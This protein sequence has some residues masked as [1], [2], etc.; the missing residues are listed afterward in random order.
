MENTLEPTTDEL[1]IDKVTENYFNV[2]CQ[3]VSEYLIPNIRERIKDGTLPPILDSENKHKPINRYLESLTQQGSKN[4]LL[5][6]GITCKTYCGRY[7]ADT[8]LEV[9]DCILHIDNKGVILGTKKILK[10][11]K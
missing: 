3:F 1:R 2:I 6:K 9:C 5:E 11:L 8:S 7:S 10:L 4:F